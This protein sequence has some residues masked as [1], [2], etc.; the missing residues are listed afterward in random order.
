MSSIVQ[1]EKKFKLPTPYVELKSRRVN[2]C[3]TPSVY[4][5][6]SIDI[7]ILL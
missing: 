1:H 5:I 2:P 6:T 7:H 4:N 3:E